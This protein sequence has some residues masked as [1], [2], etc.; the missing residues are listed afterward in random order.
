MPFRAVITDLDGTL[1]DAHHNISA[2]TFETLQLLKEKGIPLI[3]ATGRPFPDVLHTIDA[4]GLQGGYIITSNGA[5]I[6]DPERRIVVSH[7]LDPAVVKELVQL[8]LD[9]DDDDDDNN[10]VSEDGTT[11]DADAK[12]KSPPAF[13]TNMY[14]HDEWVT[15]YGVERMLAAY[16]RSGFSYKVVE[17]L[18]TYPSDGVHE[19]FYVGPHE[20]LIKLENVLQRRFEGCGEHSFSLPTIVDFVPPGVHKG[21]AM[22]HVAS[23]LNIDVADIIAFGDGMN[24]YKMLAAAG[25]GCVMQNGQQRLKEA[26]PHLEIIGSNTE[27]AVAKKLREVFEL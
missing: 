3:F 26:L 11:K 5:R 20:K 7:D 18:H 6:H 2:Y 10:N 1:L 25:K 16:A 22:A 9:G 8:T 19:V 23:L 17:E 27:D 15:N 12:K 14:R 21:S 24:D 13:S 4:C